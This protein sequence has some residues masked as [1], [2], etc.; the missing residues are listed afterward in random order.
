MCVTCGCKKFEDNHGNPKNITLS[1]FQQAASAAGTDLNGVLR[2]VSE[3]LRSYGGQN[4][5]APQQ[6]R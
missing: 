2:N 3:G 1:Q 6:Q 4:M 5:G